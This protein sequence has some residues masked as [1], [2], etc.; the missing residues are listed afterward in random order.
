MFSEINQ[1]Y[2]KPVDGYEQKR[3]FR[4]AETDCDLLVWQTPEGNVE[5][6]QFWHEDALVEWDPDR[7][8]RTGH[9]DKSSG[10]FMHYQSELYR[11]H[12]DENQDVIG[13]VNEILQN[14]Q[15]RDDDILNQITMI[16]YEIS[17]R[18]FT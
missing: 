2:L 10:A 7:G 16:L 8:I 17:N 13:V 3:W 12:T 11:F 15:V 9:V 6:F 14:N 18:N 4:D 1:E 5:K